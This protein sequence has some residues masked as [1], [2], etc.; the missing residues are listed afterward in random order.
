MKSVTIW[1]KMDRK[2]RPE[3][4]LATRR[5][6]DGVPEVDFRRGGLGTA[7]RK[8][9]AGGMNSEREPGIGFPGGW[10]GDGGRAVDFAARR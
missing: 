6:W 9:I 4:G 10:G 2:P 7:S 5:G 8:W 3:G 1:R